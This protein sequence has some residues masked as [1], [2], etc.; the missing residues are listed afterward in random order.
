[1]KFTDMINVIM[2]KKILQFTFTE[3]NKNC[4]GK[5]T[6]DKYWYFQTVISL[7]AEIH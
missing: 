4:G 7:A 3:V 2:E 6:S 5:F 1:M